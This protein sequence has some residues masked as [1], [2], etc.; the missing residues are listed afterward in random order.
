[1]QLLA[2]RL[3]GGVRKGLPTEAQGCP[4]LRAHR[5]LSSATAGRLERSDRCDR[6]LLPLGLRTRLALVD[7]FT[8]WGARCSASEGPPTSADARAAA[9]LGSALPGGLRLGQVPDAVSVD[10]TAE[11][12]GLMILDDEL[13]I[14]AITPHAPRRTLARRASG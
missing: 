2:L 4:S 13:E 12:P 14:L 10:T 6:V 1:M 11:G 3:L 5:V 9:S 7:D 8:C